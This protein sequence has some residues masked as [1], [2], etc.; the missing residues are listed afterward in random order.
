MRTFSTCDWKESERAVLHAKFS[1]PPSLQPARLKSQREL[2]FESAVPVAIFSLTDTLPVTA[3]HLYP[4][5]IN[6][7][8]LH[9]C[10]GILRNPDRTRTRTRTKSGLEKNPDSTLGLTFE[11]NRTCL[12]KTRTRLI[13]N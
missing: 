4:S 5:P 11:K 10:V 7:N 3:K 2:R 6:Y 8:Q 9:L 13:K 12:H 1:T